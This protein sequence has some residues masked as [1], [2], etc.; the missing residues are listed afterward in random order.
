MKLRVADSAPG[1]HFIPQE[2]HRDFRGLFTTG[3][4]AFL[5]LKLDFW[6]MYSNQ[7][8]LGYSTCYLILGLHEGCKDSTQCSRVNM[9]PDAGTLCPYESHTT[10]SS[11]LDPPRASAGCPRTPSYCSRAEHCITRVSSVSTSCDSFLTLLKGNHQLLADHSSGW[12]C[13][14]AFPVLFLKTCLWHY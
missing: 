5:L 7:L 13:L 6:E 10:T 4:S 12:V 9:S 14:L 3:P 8:E 2:V 11:T 1:N